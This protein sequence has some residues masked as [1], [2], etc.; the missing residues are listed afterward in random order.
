MFLL[1]SGSVRERNVV[2]RILDTD[3]SGNDE[4][5]RAGWARRDRARA[6]Q[7]MLVVLLLCVSAVTHCSGRSRTVPAVRRDAAR[8]ATARDARASL[9]NRALPYG[10]H[11]RLHRWLSPSTMYSVYRSD[12]VESYQSSLACGGDLLLMGDPSVRFASRQP[13]LSGSSVRVVYHCPPEPP[14]RRWRP[15]PPDAAGRVHIYA[16]TRETW[17]PEARVECPPLASGD[18]FGAHVA[19]STQLVAV[20]AAGIS[21]DTAAVYVFRREAR[22]FVPDGS[23]RLGCDPRVEQSRG[24][25]PRSPSPATG[26]ASSV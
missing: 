19:L 24:S 13:D 5:T 8:P 12:Q 7:V 9:V 2:E 6:T 3:A 17:R 26:S 23:S 20:S 15:D 11:L 16:R 10:V 22:S 14:S 21:R 4:M 1:V 25:A 18:L